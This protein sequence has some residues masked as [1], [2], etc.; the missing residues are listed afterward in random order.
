M[1]HHIKTPSVGI[2]VSS[3]KRGKFS[4][5]RS[6]EICRSLFMSTLETVNGMILSNPWFEVKR[7]TVALVIWYYCIHHIVHVDLYTHKFLK[8]EFSGNIALCF[9]PIGKWFELSESNCCYGWNLYLYIWSR[10]KTAMNRLL[11]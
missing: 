8:N 5:P 7:I 6:Q 3:F 4:I 1:N 9:C 2:W 11:R 10:H